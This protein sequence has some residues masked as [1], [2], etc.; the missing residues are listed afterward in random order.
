MNA[1]KIYGLVC[2]MLRAYDKDTDN[3]MAE[4]VISKPHFYE[5]NLVHNFYGD[6]AQILV[7]ALKEMDKK[8]T[9][10]TR[11]AALNRLYKSCAAAGRS[12]PSMGGFFQSGDMW[13][14]CDGYR[15]V[16]LKE[17]PDSIPAT[18]LPEAVNCNAV[19]KN[20]DRNGAI[21]AAPSAAEIKAHIAQKKQEHGKS[22]YR[23]PDFAF[24]AFPNWWCDP[25]YLLD[26]VETF[27]NGKYHLPASNVSGVYVED[28]D[29]DG[30]LLPVRHVE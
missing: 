24:E 18:G 1:E 15:F 21:F 16:R 17:K 2:E 26:M 6:A 10:K 11:L 27:P 30:F 12:R 5:D 4:K 13:A 28:K 22:W 8:S 19:V 9:P 29:G 3:S 25:R 20:E 7:E 23:N 14:L